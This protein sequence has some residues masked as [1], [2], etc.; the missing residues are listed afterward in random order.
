MDNKK[1]RNSNKISTM[2]CMTMTAHYTSTTLAT[3]HHNLLSNLSFVWLKG[4]TSFS[5]AVLLSQ[6][7]LSS[8]YLR[9][10]SS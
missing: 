7:I 2:C 6:Y 5:M 1:N 9:S 4:S 10:M 8:W 3:C